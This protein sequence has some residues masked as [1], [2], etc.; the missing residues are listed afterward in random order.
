VVWITVPGLGIRLEVGGRL[1]RKGC[2]YNGADAVRCMDST[3]GFGSSDCESLGRLLW[4]L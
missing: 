2:F 4:R 3:V 1:V